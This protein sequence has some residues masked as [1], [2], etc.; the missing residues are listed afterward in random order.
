MKLERLLDTLERGGQ[1][2]DKLRDTIQSHLEL[3]SKDGRMRLAWKFDP[4]KEIAHFRLVEGDQAAALRVETGEESSVDI[5]SRE[6]SCGLNVRMPKSLSWEFHQPRA[7]KLLTPKAA[8]LACA[9]GAT[10]GFAAWLALVVTH[11]LT[12]NQSSK[13][14]PPDEQ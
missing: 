5:W 12:G 8:G 10:A 3:E 2:L 13:N 1:A 14:T 4:G 7:E 9:V 6:G 11:K